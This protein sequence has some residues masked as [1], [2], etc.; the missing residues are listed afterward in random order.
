MERFQVE[1][2]CSNSIPKMYIYTY[3]VIVYYLT[4][5]KIASD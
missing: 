5:T 2:L 3:G 4:R 1:C